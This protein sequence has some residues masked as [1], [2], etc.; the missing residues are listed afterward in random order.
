M[1][2]LFNARQRLKGKLAGILIREQEV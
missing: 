2:R 1:S